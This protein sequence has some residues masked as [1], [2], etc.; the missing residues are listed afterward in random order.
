MVQDSGN[1][2]GSEEQFGRGEVWEISAEGVSPE[3]LDLASAW[4]N[5]GKGDPLAAL[6]LMSERLLTWRTFSSHG[7]TR[8]ALQV[9]PEHV[10][11]DGGE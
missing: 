11:R 3:I 8:G 4:L 9:F 2:S 5:A 1:S 10:E 7:M 6:I